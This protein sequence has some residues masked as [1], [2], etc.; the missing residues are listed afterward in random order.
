[1]KD[2]RRRGGAEHVEYGAHVVAFLLRALLANFPDELQRDDLNNVA[3]GIQLR[4]VGENEC[5]G[6][7]W[8]AVNKHV[9]SIAAGAVVRLDLG[10]LLLQK[11]KRRRCA[12]CTNLELPLHDLG[13]VHTESFRHTIRVVQGE[14][15]V[16]PHVAVAVV[17]VLL[18]GLH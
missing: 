4:N 1:M 12:L 6:T 18:N 8:S 11:C 15:G 3:E 9:E 5:D 14:H 7:C 2:D 17:Q 10:Q 13:R 16:A